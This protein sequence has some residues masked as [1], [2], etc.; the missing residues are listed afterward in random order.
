MARARFGPFGPPLVVVAVTAV[1][2]VAAFAFW[3]RLQADRVATD[4]TVFTAAGRVA[5]MAAGIRTSLGL[6]IV[7]T[8]GTQMGMEAMDDGGDAVAELRLD[9]AT[10]ESESADLDAL[11]GTTSHTESALAAASATEDVLT[12]L[13]GAD[14]SQ[15]IELVNEQA[16]MTAFPSL[17]AV[18]ES[19][20]VAGAV[21]AA[22][23]EAE[24]AGAGDTAFASI[25][26]VAFFVPALAVT[27]L[28]MSSRRRVERLSLLAEIDKNVALLQ[29]RDDLIAGISHQLR[30]PLTGIVGYT[31][32]LIASPDD[33]HL[34]REGLSTIKTEA[35]E[36]TRMIDDLLVMARLEDGLIEI[37]QRPLD[38]IAAIERVA[39]AQ[40]AAVQTSLSPALV[41]GDRLRLRHILTNLVSNA[42]RHGGPE[43]LIEAGPIDGW[44]RVVVADDGDGVPAG[45]LDDVFRPYV[46]SARDSLVTGSM[47]LGLAVAKQLADQM[48]CR[49]THQRLDGYTMFA[50]DMP[51]AED[52]TTRI[53]A[54]AG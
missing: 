15:A 21:A 33:F 30:T 20:A 3:D 22:R 29:A 16:I 37:E 23:I 5:S 25:L 8:S 45:L 9:L 26:L 36:L 10:L 49:L 35:G 24:Q 34:R 11:Q 13:A 32:A 1:S 41:I 17:I 19:A 52:A 53:T 7:L 2:T 43:V 38:P 27:T 6:T 31:D 14:S 12:A 40:S 18:E 48:G 44:Y 46:H 28:W 51:L 4:R 39:E 47:G 50:L 54:S 42:V